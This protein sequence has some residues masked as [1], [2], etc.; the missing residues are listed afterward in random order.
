MRGRCPATVSNHTSC[1]C[2]DA[3]CPVCRCV[4]VKRLGKSH[5]LSSRRSPEIDPTL[6]AL[7]SDYPRLSFTPPCM[8][9][10]DAELLGGSVEV[11]N[12]GGIH[13]GGRNLFITEEAE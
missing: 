3:R 1:R 11:G 10:A 7:T 12:R 2:L 13:V 8:R 5:D 9:P 6:A 4:L